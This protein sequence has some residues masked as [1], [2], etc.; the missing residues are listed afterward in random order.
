MG[1]TLWARPRD[2]GGS[3]FG[4][5]LARYP[6]EVDGADGA[7]PVGAAAGRPAPGPTAGVESSS[8]AA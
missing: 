5:S 4:F 3:E 1:G 8:P 2:G 6:D 7:R